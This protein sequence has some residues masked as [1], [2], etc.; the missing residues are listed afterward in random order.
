MRLPPAFAYLFLRASAR[1]AFLAASSN[2]YSAAGCSSLVSS[3][4]LAFFFSFFLRFASRFFSSISACVSTLAESVVAG[5]EVEFYCTP[6]SFSVRSNS[7]SSRRF[8]S[9]LLNYLTTTKKCYHNNDLP[10]GLLSSTGSSFSGS[11]S[12]DSSDSSSPSYY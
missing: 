2:T 6:N 10:F 12:S 1:A 4:F 7:S 11:S 5:C 3:V 8:C 9:F